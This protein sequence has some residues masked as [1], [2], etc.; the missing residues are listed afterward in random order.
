[1]PVHRKIMKSKA[2][3]NEAPLDKAI[4]DWF[5][6]WGAK[7]IRN[8]MAISSY[9]GRESRQ[10]HFRENRPK[11]GD[12]NANTL[13]D[14][15][16]LRNDSSELIRTNPVAASAININKTHVV[17]PGIRYHSRINRKVLGMEEDEANE[18]QDMAEMEFRLATDTLDFAVDRQASF[19]DQVLLAYGSQMERG[20]S[21]GLFVGK[22]LPTNPYSTK[23]QLFEADR[24]CNDPDVSSRDTKNL[25]AGIAI[26]DDG[27]PKAIHLRSTHPNT[28]IGGFKR[29][30]RQIP[31]FTPSGRRNILHLNP[32]S[33]IGQM[34]AVPYLAGVIGHLNLLSDYSD[35]E[36]QAAVTAACFTVFIETETGNTGIGNIEENDPPRDPNDKDYRIKPAA[37]V[38][39]ARGEKVSTAN[40]GRPN[41]GYDPFVISILREVGAY[42]GIGRELLL[43]DF[44]KNFSASRAAVQ[45]AYK[46]FVVERAFLVRHWC[47]IIQERIIEE[48]VFLGRLPAPGFEDPLLRQ[49]YLGA[50]WTG[51][52]QT[53]LDEVKSAKAS[54]SRLA[55]K[56]STIAEETAILGG[57][58]AQNVP[59][60][61]KEIELFGDGKPDVGGQE[62][63][64]SE[65]EEEDD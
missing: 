13:R 3:V 7:R 40:P 28:E 55:N 8:R 59:Q 17:G 16:R 58:F 52:P 24:V 47:A 12:A 60:I 39:L 48:S 36:L 56:T 43:I 42:L 27:E 34:R 9:Y 32:I 64:R 4:N 1:L 31:Y 37:L 23:V 14:L 35:A 15:P 54:T 57:D 6:G 61:Q 33:R 30:W 21:W 46:R 18:W 53:Q 11:A 65:K 44:M 50:I 38:E 19:S 29:T 20:D 63:R 41:S 22:K 49:A 51:P 62:D 25:I 2:K 45:T 10:R 26:K 5:P